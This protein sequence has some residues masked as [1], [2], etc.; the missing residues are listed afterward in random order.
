MKTRKK[1]IKLDMFAKFYVY[2]LKNIT[3]GFTIKD[4]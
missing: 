4:I 3:M 1:V 2:I